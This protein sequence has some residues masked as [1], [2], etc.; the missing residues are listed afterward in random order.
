MSF[1]LFF[2]LLFHSKGIV[3][4]YLMLFLLLFLLLCMSLLSVAFI[5]WNRQRERE[6]KSSSIEEDTLGL[7]YNVID[8]YLSCHDKKFLHRESWPTTK[9][10]KKRHNKQLT[11]RINTP[12]D[13]NETNR[14]S[15]NIVG[16]LTVMFRI[17]SGVRFTLQRFSL[18]YS[19]APICQ[20]YTANIV[21]ISICLWLSEC[22]VL[23]HNTCF[24]IDLWNVD[25]WHHSS[26]NTLCVSIHS[27]YL[28]FGM[29]SNE[30][31]ARL[32]VISIPKKKY[33]I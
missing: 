14:M 21:S 33:H 19:N 6:K 13:E 10:K 2:L 24:V 30:S 15:W 26:Y 18:I 4:F 28:Y 23:S 7:T 32:C 5:L 22:V 16:G 12:H 29:S 1:F 20:Y 17:D 25:S 31:T 8:C 9:M 11:T 3:L 27:V